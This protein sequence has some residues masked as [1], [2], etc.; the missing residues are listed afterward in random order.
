MPLH[1]KFLV[2]KLYYVTSCLSLTLGSKIYSTKSFARTLAYFSFRKEILFLI[3]V[4]FLYDQYDNT[5]YDFNIKVY[6]TVNIEVTKRSRF[7]R[8]F[9]NIDVRN[10]I[11][12]FNPFLPQNIFS[13]RYFV[14]TEKRDWEIRRCCL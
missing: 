3:F 4:L 2:T 13:C 1:T 11:V 10:P 12:L 8:L 5:R 7:K 6:V 14:I 9:A